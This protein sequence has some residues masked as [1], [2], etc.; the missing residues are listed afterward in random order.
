M[1]FILVADDRPLNRHF[2]MTLLTY[3]GHFVGEA[4][5][6]VEALHAA[7]ERKPDLII[8]DVVM[9]RMD[10]PAL[11]RA[12]RADGELKDVPIIFYSA[13]YR[14]V[15]AQAIAK[16]CGVEHVIT[17]PSDPEVILQTIARALG[18]AAPAAPPPEAPADP[19]EIIARLQLAN[20]RMTGLIELMAH[21]SGE[22]DPHELLRTAC[23]AI[24]KIFGADYAVLAVAGETHADGNVDRTRL[25]TLLVRVN[26]LLGTKPIRAADDAKL[27][28][29]ARDLMPDA[30][31]ALLLPMRSRGNSYGWM[32]LA[33]R[34]DAPPFS[35]DDE[36]LAFAA[37]GQIRAEHES[38]RAIE[39]ELRTYR[40]DLAA[41]VD[42]APV[43][44]IAFD[45][46]C[47]VQVW[48]PAAERTFGW[49]AAEVVGKK[50]P[51]MPPELEEEFEG[52]ARECLAGN[53]ITGV[54]QRRVR[55]D[56]AALDVYV[57]LAPLH[58]ANGRARG[59]VS[60]VNDVTALRA[61][62]ESLRALSAR[63]LS[64]QEEERTHL[65]RELHDDLGQLLTALK[66]DAAKLLQD[67]ARGV[68]P[69]KRVTEGLLPLIDVTMDTVV[70]L[71][72]ELR[73]S[74]IGEMGLAAA[75]KKTL[76]D[77]HERT[78][79]EVE[80]FIGPAALHVSEAAA[81]AA[82]RIVEEAL[83][84]VARHSGATRVK[85]TVEAGPD[86]LEVVV[87]DNGKG[88]SDAAR[89]A[90]DAYGLI[91]MKERAVV[92]GGTVEVSRGQQRG[93][94][95]AARIPLGNDSR[96]HRR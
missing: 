36:R 21:L 52:L 39:A 10:G 41:L 71:V 70:R 59:F 25:E 63:V 85:V 27:V 29:A 22:R 3:Y 91:G 76:A 82:F 13:S 53:T 32:L 43:P 61:S 57:H 74:R 44:I 18:V 7:R 56:G 26:A 11:A 1:P 72:S 87:E 81:T 12:L 77:F 60:I 94:I 75:I 46:H 40:E 48:N 4:A 93:T 8:A 51:A 64:I 9:P 84:N 37:A 65:A 66:I 2:L 31:A 5:D 86:A 50:N 96:V 54:E 28:A 78:D 49:L 20:I 89:T 68:K 16:A 45:R 95:V 15:E 35:I 80:R 14:E 55:K 19:R 83:A 58:D 69:A 79:I 73:P 47:I 23:L 67:L 6:G 92:L 90:P 30:A 62:R 17:K 38:L 42:A 33:N 24:R 34:R 88:I